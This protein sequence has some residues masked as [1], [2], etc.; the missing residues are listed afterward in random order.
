MRAEGG[1]GV[2]TTAAAHVQREG[3]RFNGQLG[4]FSEEQLPGLTELA[5]DLHAAGSMSLAQLH[6]AGNRSPV[7][8]IFTTPV[9]PSDDPKQGARGLTADEVQSTF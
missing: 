8:L 1:F 7:D 2:T 3:Q 9:C 6:H 4:V 5:E